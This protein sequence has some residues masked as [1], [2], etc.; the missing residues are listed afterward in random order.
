MLNEEELF[1]LRNVFIRDIKDTIFHHYHKDS[2]YVIDELIKELKE[3]K[4]KTRV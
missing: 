3:L 1:L 2:I 4:K